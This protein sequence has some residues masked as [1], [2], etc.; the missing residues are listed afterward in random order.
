MAQQDAASFQSSPLLSVA[1]LGAAAVQASIAFWWQWPTLMAGALPMRDPSEKDRQ[2]RDKA[3][4]ARVVAAQIEAMRSL[5]E[6]INQKAPA[7]PVE[8]VRHNA[9]AKPKRRRKR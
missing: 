5:A 7:A 9:K 3:A 8:P 4:T 1:E 6:S 2:E